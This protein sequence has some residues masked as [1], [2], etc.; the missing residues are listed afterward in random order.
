M[1]AKKNTSLEARGPKRAAR[2]DL[3]I[4]GA[5]PGGYT[6]ALYAAQKGLKTC[7][8][9][10]EQIG[11]V[12][13][14][15]GCIP[16]KTYY[17]SAYFLEQIKQSDKVG[18]NIPNFSVDLKKINEH[19][20]NIIKK[21]SDGVKLLLEKRGVDVILGKAVFDSPGILKVDR[22]LI[23]AADIIIASGSKD[24]ELSSM[25]FSDDIASSKTVWDFHE[26]PKQLLIVGGGVIGCEMANIF[27]EFGSKVTIVEAQDL[28]L[29]AIDMDISKKLAVILKRK[30]VNVLTSQKVES[31]EDNT[32]VISNA[33][34]IFFDKA[35]VCVGREPVFRDLF[36]ENIGVVI[37]RKKINV[38]KFLRTNIKNIYAIGDCNGK[39][40]LAHVASFEAIVAVDNILGKK[41]EMDYSSV[42]NCIFTS[43]EIAT[44]GISEKEMTNDMQISKVMY[45]SLGK[46]HTANKTDGFIKIIFEKRS[47]I[48]FGVSI[49]G[50]NAT[51]LITHASFLISQKKT[52]EDI[53]QTIYA[54]PTF[55]EIFS[56]AA[57]AAIG[58]PINSI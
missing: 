33:K 9:E 42:P 41:R 31:V 35:I 38:D 50:E 53:L 25:P 19:R 26:I 21:L 1:D 56:E 55:S 30:G 20:Q 28:L 10:Q 46:A 5:G 4:I 57:H 52:I 34:R 23:E 40:M 7:L 2:Y 17:K 22:Q 11:G 13:L 24:I 51:E 54:H 49:M 48:V 16:T 29:P 6:A 39:S 14:N 58:F 15:T 37:D 8:I 12:C 32:V 36:L 27:S 47:L 44:C 18:V 3:A 43:P 45:S